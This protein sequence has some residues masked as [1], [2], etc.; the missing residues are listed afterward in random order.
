[1]W[2]RK[3]VVNQKLTEQVRQ[4]GKETDRETDGYFVSPPVAGATG[5]AWLDAR[6]RKKKKKNK[7]KDRKERKS[8]TINETLFV[9]VGTPFYP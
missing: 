6:V 4:T 1:M 3:C 9:L 5:L 2:S 8:A 7:E